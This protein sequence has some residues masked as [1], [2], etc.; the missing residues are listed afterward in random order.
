[1][2]T[3]VAGAL[4]PDV[5]VTVSVGTATLRV[6]E[7]ADQLVARADKALYQFKQQGRNRTTQA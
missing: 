1:M 6:D 7:D 2:R 4:W 5:P 3:V